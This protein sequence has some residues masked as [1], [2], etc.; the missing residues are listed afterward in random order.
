MRRVLVVHDDAVSLERLRRAMQQRE[1]GWE[2]SSA[3]SVEDA[4]QEVERSHPDVVVTVAP[5]GSTFP[6]LN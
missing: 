2:M 4:W 6:G 3:F 5:A 1:P